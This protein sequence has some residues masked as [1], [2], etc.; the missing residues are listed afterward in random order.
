MIL[1]LARDASTDPATATRANSR[2]CFAPGAYVRYTALIAASVGLAPETVDGAMGRAIAANAERSVG[3]IFDLL[4]R[5]KKAKLTDGNVDGYFAM[6][7][8]PGIKASPIRSF[9]NSLSVHFPDIGLDAGMRAR[10]TDSA[11]G[12]YSLTRVSAGPI[13]WGEIDA[14]TAMRVVPPDAAYVVPANIPAADGTEAAIEAARAANAA[15]IRA[16]WSA[17]NRERAIIRNAAEAPWDVQLAALIPRR[18]LAIT[19][20]YLECAGR[21]IDDWVQG[22]R[23][24]DELPSQRVRSFRDYI[25]KYLE[26]TG[27][28]EAVTG[29]AVVNLAQYQGAINGRW[30][31]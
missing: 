26:I 21:G 9:V 10:L 5:S 27:N 23:A 17:A 2:A 6:L 3:W 14:L 7:G 28:S 18:I 12:R 19:A 8:N 20:I 22:N 16:A 1:T 15:A 30:T 13:I 24:V 25:K 4:F 11:W 29:A 31:V